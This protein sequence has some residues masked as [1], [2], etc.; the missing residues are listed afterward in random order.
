MISIKESY[1][2]LLL[3]TPS[4]DF[5]CHHD[6]T[7]RAPTATTPHGDDPHGVYTS[8]YHLLL[9]IIYFLFMRRCTLSN[10][11]CTL[12]YAPLYASVLLASHTPVTIIQLTNV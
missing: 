9:F 12:L 10:M 3:P 1:F 11:L 6:A 4:Q 8:I 2:I 7:R 5:E